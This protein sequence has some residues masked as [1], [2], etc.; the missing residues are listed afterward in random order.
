[1]RDELAVLVIAKT[2]ERRLHAHVRVLQGEKYTEW[3][4][5]NKGFAVGPYVRSYNGPALANTIVQYMTPKRP[6]KPT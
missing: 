1:M 2:V 3:R 6:T 4:V 5:G